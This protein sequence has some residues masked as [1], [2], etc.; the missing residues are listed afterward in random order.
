M[1][2]DMLPTWNPGAEFKVIERA[3]HFY[4]GGTNEVVLIIKN[5]LGRY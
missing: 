5:F 4:W 3:D 2:K 1:I